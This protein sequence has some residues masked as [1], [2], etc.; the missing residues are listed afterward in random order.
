MVG[1][2]T[3]RGKDPI[4]KCPAIPYTFCDVYRFTGD[5]VAELTAFVIRTDRSNQAEGPRTTPTRWQPTGTT[6]RQSDGADM[7]GRLIRQPFAAGSPSWPVARVEP[8]AGSRPRWARRARR[9]SVLDAAH[10]LRDR[11][12]QTTNALNGSKTRPNWSH[13]LEGQ[14]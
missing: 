12:A 11:R 9:S 8:D 4:R 5:K 10:V 14:A 13:G 7:S 6:D 1:D 3:V 2:T